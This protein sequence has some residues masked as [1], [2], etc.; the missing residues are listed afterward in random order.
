MNSILGIWKTRIE[1]YVKETRSYLKYMLNDHLV[2]V[3]I[4]LAGGASW[5]SK[6]LKEMPEGFPAYWVM[7]VIF[8]FILT[9][10]YVRTLI[11]E[12]DL[13]FF[14]AARSKDGAV[15]S[16]GFPIQFVDANFFRWPPRPSLWRRCIL[17]QAAR[18]FPRTSSC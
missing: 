18:G 17:K 5:Y 2:I 3:M 7:A 4:F 8:S 11:K 1:E 15:F 10:S 13:V 16:A 12:A 6:W 9:G 14:F